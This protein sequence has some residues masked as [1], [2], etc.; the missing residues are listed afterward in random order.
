MPSKVS[1]SA[2][3]RRE[4]PLLRPAAAEREE[5]IT[6][7]ERGTLMHRVLQFIGTEEMTPEQVAARV[8]ALAEK[9]LIDEAL[10]AHVHPGQIAAYLRSDTAARARRSARRLF[11]QPFCLRLRAREAGLAQSDEAVIVQGVIDLCFLEDGR[12]VLVDYK[13]D[14][15]KTSAREAAEK[16]ALQLSLYQKALERIT[17][18]PVAEKIIFLLSAGEAV[19]L[20]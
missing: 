4:E 18:I 15:V 10:A 20:S 19:R 3:K 11:E 17:R 12:W 9:G 13:T 7:A 2:L 14:A 8:K 16:Y 6:A 1:V 5:D